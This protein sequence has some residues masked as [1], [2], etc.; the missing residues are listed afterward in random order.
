MDE[1]ILGRDD[2]I[3]GLFPHPD[4]E[5]LGAGILLQRA[6]AV[7]AAVLPVFLTSGEANSWPQRVLDRRICLNQEDRRRFAARRQGEAR[8]ALEI[9]GLAPHSAL[10]L[11]FPDTGLTARLLADGDTLLATLSRLVRK[12]R[13]TLVLAP[14]LADC[15]PDHSATAI[16]AIVLMRRHGFRLLGYPTHTGA[17]AAQ[18][19]LELRG[20][21]GELEAKRRAIA[22]HRSQLVFRRRFHLRFAAAPEVYL[23]LDTTP[24]KP[25][26]R[27]RVEGNRLEVSFRLP[28]GLRSWRRPALTVVTLGHRLSGFSLRLGRRPGPLPPGVE[29]VHSERR[30]GSTGKLV[31][32][33]TEAPETA[34]VKISRPLFLYDEVG[35]VQAEKS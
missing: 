25:E 4:D 6:A 20:S 22:A 21:E 26:V 24:E 17:L 35:F 10:F 5:S 32:R 30:L 33:L 9:L 3:L 29:F 2:R 16:L 19:E 27:A 23:P 8:A 1:L 14:V 15:H 18:G 7:G 31:L 11:G 28:V 13:P 12:F 34:F